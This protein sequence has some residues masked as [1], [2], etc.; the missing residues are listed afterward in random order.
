MQGWALSALGDP[1]QGIAALQ[2]GLE[3]YESTDARLIKP[4]ILTLL[5]EMYGWAGS[6]QNGI[7]ALAGAFGPGNTTDVSFYEAETLR[8]QGELIRQSQAGDG[9]EYFDRALKLARRQHARGLE[10]RAVMSVGR[11]SLERGGTASAH[12]LISAVYRTFDASRTDPDL[13]DARAL[14][15]A[16]SPD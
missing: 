1:D 2:R 8:I 11:A 10:L 3:T 5:A 9:R 16:L 6:P 15:D 7:D 14:L 4:Y 13:I 12:A